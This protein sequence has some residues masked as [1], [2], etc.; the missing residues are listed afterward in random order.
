MLETGLAMPVPVYARFQARGFPIIGTTLDYFDFR[1]LEIAAGRALALLGECVLGATVAERLDLEPGDGL[2]SS[3]ETLFDLAGIYPLKMKVVGTLKRS[4][5]A[6]DLAVF[7]DLKT[8]WVIE[9]LGH[10]HQD[11]S[12]PESRGLL[13]D[14]KTTC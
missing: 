6:D 3:P 5:S 8:A 7:V 4:H 12:K 14:M 10:G 9:G 2:V 1:A 13:L 11:L